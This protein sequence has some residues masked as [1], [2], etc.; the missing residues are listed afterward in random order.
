MI[1][2]F[3]SKTKI[4]FMLF[5]PLFFYRGLISIFRLTIVMRFFGH[6]CVLLF[7]VFHNLMRVNS[8]PSL[9]SWKC[10]LVNSF[11][12]TST[13][14]RFISRCY[15][16]I[17]LVSLINLSSKHL[18]WSMAALCWS[19]QMKLI[20]LLDNSAWFLCQWILFNS[21]LCYCWFAWTFVHW[22]K[23]Y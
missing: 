12:S 22:N 16:I 20:F 7:K 8:I 5:F 14:V 23:I 4:I 9:L 19:Y 13:N 15:G 10:L 6:W 17:N 1:K 3:F 2:F 21:F 11:L 18:S